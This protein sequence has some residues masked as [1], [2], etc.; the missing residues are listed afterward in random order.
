MQRTCFSHP[1]NSSRPSSAASLVQSPRR[2]AISGRDPCNSIPPTPSPISQRLVGITPFPYNSRRLQHGN[3]EQTV[4]TKKEEKKTK[5]SGTR[6]LAGAYAS[7]RKAACYGPDPEKG[8][9]LSLKRTEP[10]KDPAH[11]INAEWHSLWECQGASF[12]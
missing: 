11:A 12:D 4:G 3:V 10:F 6:A 2:P 7:L 1:L 8:H 9:R 5:A